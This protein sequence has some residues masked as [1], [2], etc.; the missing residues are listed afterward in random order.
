MEVCFVGFLPI[1]I[2]A[3]DFPT[4]RYTATKTHFLTF[5]LSLEI[6]QLNM[7]AFLTTRLS[8]TVHSQPGSTVKTKIFT[9]ESQN[10][11]I[12]EHSLMFSTFFGDIFHEE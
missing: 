11:G 10:R 7:A 4:A 3:Y 6:L 2:L 5:F 9:N 1:I 12:L 8:V